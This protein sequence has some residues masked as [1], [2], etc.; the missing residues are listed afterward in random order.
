LPTSMLRNIPSTVIFQL[1]DALAK[2]AK[3][4]SKLSVSARLT[5]NAQQLVA[6]PIAVPAGADD[7]RSCL[8]PARFL[9]GTSCSAQNFWLQAREALGANGVAAIG[10]YDLD[11]VGCG[12]SVTPRGWEAIHNPSSPDLKL[13]LFFMPNVG[14]SCLSAKKIDLDN[15][16][17]ALTVGDSMKEIGDLDG[18]RAALNT[19]REAMSCALPWNK[20]IAAIQGF[21]INCNYAEADLRGNPNRAA[22]LT[23]FVDFV[24]A[25]N[26]LNWENRV[27]FLAADDL[28]HA[29]ASWRG[30][31]AAYFTATTSDKAKG[32]PPEK[33]QK[34]SDMDDICRR[35][36][37]KDCKNPAS[38]CKTWSGRKLKHVCSEKLPNG[39]RCRKDHPRMDHK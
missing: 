22:M 1:N 24:F 12:G 32:G 21:M 35:Y 14:N 7:R 4:A 34:L 9:G 37:R 31:R 5:S 3:S 26:A 29:W 8:H 30:Q 27:P 39:R 11:S 19:A 2:E 13:K 33:K 28:A 17:K 20:S 23:E 10:N 18:F 15:G 25:R 36:N 16:E 38:D 6:N